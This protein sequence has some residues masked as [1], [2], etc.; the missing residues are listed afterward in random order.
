VENP[1]L[2]EGMDELTTVMAAVL[3]NPTRNCAPFVDISIARGLD[4]YTG[5]VYEVKFSDYP[6]Y[7]T[8]CGGGRYE[9]LAGNFVRQKLPGVG[10]SIGLTRI[11]TKLLKEQKITRGAQC[12]T[13]VMVVFLPGNNRETLT[14][15]SSQLRDRGLNV[16]TYHDQIH[17]DKQLRY[18]SRKRI[19]YVW[20]AGS[21]GN[22]VHEVRNMESGEQSPADPAS[23][24]PQ[25]SG[26]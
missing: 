13:D 26:G 22:A 10:I 11:F 2:D 16:E 18:A 9:N 12:P 23:W 7:P 5:T 20:F 6:E 8:I 3:T 17:L 15:I 25:P 14:A 19:P 24:Q 4:Y 21:G 1:L